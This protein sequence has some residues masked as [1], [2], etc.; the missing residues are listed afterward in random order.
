MMDFGNSYETSRYF[1]ITA[2]YIAVVNPESIHRAFVFAGTAILMHILIN[3]DQ[4]SLSAINV[5]Q[6]IV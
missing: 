4:Q 6:K 5:M 3:L 1:I 2:T